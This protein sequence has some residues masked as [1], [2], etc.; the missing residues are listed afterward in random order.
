MRKLKSLGLLF[1]S[2]IC[3]SSCDWLF[4][5]KDPVFHYTVYN[6]AIGF[7]DA[8]GSD[9][10]KGIGLKDRQSGVS[11]ED[12]KW[13]EVD[14]DQYRLDIMV[15]IPC[16]NWSNDTYDTPSR[17][18]TGPFEVKRPQLDIYYYDEICY[19]HNYF[20]LPVEDCPDQRKLTYKLKCP[21]VF[22]DKEVHELVTYWDIPTEKPVPTTYA[23]CLRIEFGGDKFIPEKREEEGRGY[24]VVINWNGRE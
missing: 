7:R 5:H 8:S 23:K 3:F 22:G 19:L 2:V 14:S 10:V 4:G 12:A 11:M 24:W 20:E 15:D 9:L 6:L 1:L 13:G 17:P 18:A 21:Y 16:W